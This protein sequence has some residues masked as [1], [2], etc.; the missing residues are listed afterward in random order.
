[1]W[2]QSI[3]HFNLSP[4]FEGQKFIWFA[5]CRALLVGVEFENKFQFQYYNT[6]YKE[7]DIHSTVKEIIY[8]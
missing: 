6:K 1:M 2:P 5:T 8:R 3:L 7:Y 4:Y